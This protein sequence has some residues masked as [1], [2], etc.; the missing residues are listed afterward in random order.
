MKDAI[1]IRPFTGS[2]V[3]Y[4]IPEVAR[5]RI[6]V[7]REYPYLYDGDMGYEANYLRTYSESRDSVI[8]IAFAGD[9]VVGASTAV[10]LRYEMEEIKRPFLE[11]NIDPQDVFYL[12]ESVLLPNYRGRGIGVRFFQERE[13]H[14]SLI[15]NFHWSAFC[16]IERPCDHPRR[17][18]DYI[19]LDEFWKRRGY[20]KRPEFRTTLSWKDL[21]E[22]SPT[23]KSMVFWMK[24]L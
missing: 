3:E 4:Y 24:Q 15:G 19:T 16:T 9:Q 22:S 5:L 6:E 23:P 17:P 8:V 12:G 14:A 13:A 11:H 1:T 18:G 20:I 2:D 21:D 10:P 7:F